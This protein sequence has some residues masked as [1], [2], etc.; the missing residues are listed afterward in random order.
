MTI[1]LIIAVLICAIG[2]W[3]KSVNA[4]VLLWYLDKNGVPYP[5]KKEIDEGTRWV[6]SHM[7]MDLFD[8]GRE[9]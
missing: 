2:W 9:H 6:V 1:I 4:L 5:S 8:A 3:L 7:I